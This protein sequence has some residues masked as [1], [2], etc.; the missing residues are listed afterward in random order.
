MQLSRNTSQGKTKN[1]LIFLVKLILIFGSI[2]V[3]VML[4]N[5]IDF[6]SPNKKIEKNIPNENFKTIK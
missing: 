5:R 2:F 1:F 3:V 4:L 6:P